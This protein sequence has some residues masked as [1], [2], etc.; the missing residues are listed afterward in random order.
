MGDHCGPWIRKQTLGRGG[1]GIVSL[2]LNEV[3]VLIRFIKIFYLNQNEILSP[4]I[5]WSRNFQIKALRSKPL[6]GK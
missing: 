5:P 1:F 2:W 6:Y 4:P 3:S